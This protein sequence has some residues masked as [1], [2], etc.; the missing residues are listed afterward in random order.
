MRT[1]AIATLLTLMIATIAG[2]AD[3]T[4]LM[5]APSGSAYAQ[6]NESGTNILPNGRFV[7]PMGKMIRVQPHPYG[8]TMSADGRWV[9]AVCSDDP[10]LAILDL[11]NPD[12]PAIAHIPENLGDGKGVLDAAFMGAAVDPANKVVY[13]AGGGDWSVMAFNLETRERLFRI[14]CAHKNDDGDFTFGYLG[15]LRL[16]ADGKTIYA[17]DQ[18]N[19]RLLII[20][21]EGRKV[22]RSIAVGRYPFGVTLSPDGTK[23]YVAN[24]GMYEYSYVRDDKGG[25]AAL[26]FP[27]FG[28]PSRKAKKGVT[29]DGKKVEG[30]GDPNDIRG[31]SV[32]TVD[33]SK[34]GEEKVVG[35]T[36][37]GHLVGEKLED[38]PA[39]GGSSPNSIAATEQYVYVSNGSNDSI[40][41]ID[42]KSGKREHDIDLVLDPRVNHIR[43]MIPFGVAL[44]PDRED[45]LRCGSGHQRGGR[46]AVVGRESAGPH[47]DG[48]V[49]EQARR[50]ARRHEALR[51]LRERPRLRTERG[52]GAQAGRSHRNRRTHARL[53]QHHRRPIAAGIG[54]HDEAGG[55]E[56][57]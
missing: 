9:I 54:R 34:P 41:V 19:F 53:H 39:V 42:P 48:V 28:V 46:R 18:S 55:Q 50:V 15:D 11:A 22:L 31:M 26:D 16:S 17:V 13:I 45:P 43:G 35:K 37:T 1:V 14:D 49:P 4:L 44:S 36:K 23:A 32:W 25:I 29:I 2:A 12:A 24:V 38:F 30:L 10:Q 56:Q 3:N 33:I 7:T 47:S 5:R 20:D 52:S 6:Q 40:T 51:L 21:V 57:R 27:P 8:M